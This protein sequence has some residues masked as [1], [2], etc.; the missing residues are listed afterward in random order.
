MA[1]EKY[2]VIIPNLL[3]RAITSLVQQKQAR[4]YRVIEKKVEDFGSPPNPLQMRSYVLQQNPRMLL[5][6]G[7]YDK[8]PGYPIRRQYAADGDTVDYISDAYFSMRSGDRVPRVPTGRLSSNSVTEL[9]SICDLLVRYPVSRDPSW[10]RRVILC[11]WIPNAT[12]DEDPEDG[13]WGCLSEIGHAFEPLF[14]FEHAYRD[15]DEQRDKWRAWN[16]SKRL[17]KQAIEQG[18]LVVRYL[19]HGSTRDWGNVGLN[20][21][22]TDEAFDA[23]DVRNLN[24]GDQVPLV[25]S[26]ACLT[27]QIRQS[28]S[29]AEVWQKNG[30]AIGIFAAAQPSATYWNNRFSPRVFNRL[31]SVQDRRIGDILLEAMKQLDRDFDS[32]ISGKLRW[33]FRHTTRMYRYLGDPDTILAAP[34]PVVR[35]GDSGNRAGKVKEIAVSNHRTRQLVTAV[36]TEAGKMRLIS[37]RVNQDGAVL[38]T[39]DNGSQ[40]YVP[41]SRISITDHHP[42]V[43]AYRHESGKL[44]L[45]CWAVNVSGVITRI[46]DSGDQAGIVDRT[47]IVALSNFLLLTGVRPSGHQLRLITWRLNNRGQFSRLSDNRSAVDVKKIKEIALTRIPHET[48]GYRVVSS[49][50]TDGDK[51]MQYAWDIN[52]AGAITLRGH[53]SSPGGGPYDKVSI[54]RSA[55]NVHGH[56]VTAFRDRKGCL[57]LISSRISTHGRITALAESGYQAGYIKDLALMAWQDG[58]LCAVRTK[59]GKLKLIDFTMIPSGEFIRAGDSSQQAG[60]A[61]CIS[62]CQAPLAG[63]APIVTAVRAINGGRLKIITWKDHS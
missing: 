23:N 31:V 24:V 34:K 15:S 62:L 52:Y 16:S 25:I 53:W 63:D 17:L 18:A 27:G 58:V 9:R 51:L 54:I 37:W 1:T 43:V 32:R 42:H 12:R 13:G 2:L 57:K 60:R 35:K 5:L 59:A 45:V 4:G 28:H 20:N 39:G 6:V 22:V 49:V 50:R 56:L 41:A 26:A 36:R 55:L 19:G 46:A 29:F 44:R 40:G 8:T 48:R 21:Y 61:D 3:R 11:G 14:E 7:D 30:K 10:R 33:F 38:R 47:S